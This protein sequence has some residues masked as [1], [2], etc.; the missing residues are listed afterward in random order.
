MSRLAVE[1]GGR[2]VP[3]RIRRNPRARRLILRLDPDADGALVTL[4]PGAGVERAL[5]LV[6]GKADWIVGRLDALPP[7]TPFA[8]GGRVPFLGRQYRVRHRPGG[9]R[10]VRVQE[11]EIQV[12]GRLEHLARRLTDWFR[13]QARREI[14]GRVEIMT[15]RLGKRAGRITVRDPRS[16][17]GSCSAAGNLSFSWRLVMMPEEVLDYVVAHEV[18]HLEHPNHGPG[19]WRTVSAL[20]GNAET[21]RA[22]LKEKGPGFHRFG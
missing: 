3:I 11:T 14:A 20:T 2:T 1:L 9:A 7:R 16:R 12:G 15:E 22:W 21:S 10:P 19:F 17:W 5:D 8:D 13:R 4:P 18:A 6:R